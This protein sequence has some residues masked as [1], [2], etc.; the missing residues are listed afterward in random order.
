MWLVEAFTVFFFHIFCNFAQNFVSFAK[1]C[2]LFN[3]N[4]IGFT[5]KDRGAWLIGF[6]RVFWSEISLNLLN[7]RL[8]H[9]KMSQMRFFIQ[10]M[11]SCTFASYK[12]LL[13]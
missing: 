4:V 2:N 11:D 9:Q 13:E 10:K 6:M 1:I 5:F 8:F 3:N 12:S 7:F